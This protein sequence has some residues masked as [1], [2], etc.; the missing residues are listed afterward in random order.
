MRKCDNPLPPKRAKYEHGLEGALLLLDFCDRRLARRLGLEQLL[1]D[2]ARRVPDPVF[3]L[4]PPRLE[5][6]ALEF[7]RLV[8]RFREVP[9]PFDLGDVADG[10]PFLAE[11]V[12]VLLPDLLALVNDAKFFARVRFPDSQVRVVRARQDE[13]RVKSVSGREDTAREVASR[14]SPS[15]FWAN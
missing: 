12:A 1:V 13:A 7:A 14:V 6:L 9:R 11:A 3:L 4:G 8:D 2:P 10:A 15:N 5:H